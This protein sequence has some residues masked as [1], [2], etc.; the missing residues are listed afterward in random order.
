[1]L[2][3]VG[4][5][6]HRHKPVGVLSGGMKQRLALALPFGRPICAGDGRADLQPRH[7]GASQLLELLVQVKQ[8]GKT[9]IFTSHRIEESRIW[10]MM[11][12]LWSAGACCF[13]AC[14]AELASLGLRTQVRFILPDHLLDQALAVL[15][16]DGG[17]AET[18]SALSTS[19]P[20][21]RRA[22]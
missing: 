9:I 5:S 4:L 22:H 14:P 20:V 7:G 16:S 2:E 13:A 19:R 21:R 12:P 17:G 18:A 8:A 15:H 1:M 10:R 3:Q 11:W 6:E